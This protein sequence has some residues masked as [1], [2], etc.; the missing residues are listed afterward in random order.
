M[1]IRIGINGVGRVGRNLWRIIHTTAPD[2]TVAAA[3][4]T[5]DLSTVAHLL[6]Y[7][8][9]RGRFPATV[10]TADGALV[11][12][13]VPVPFSHEPTPERVDWG[14]HGVDLVIEAT[15]EFVRGDRA[16]GHLRG[17]APLVVVTTATPDADVCLMMGINE[18]AFDRERHRVISNSC[19]SVYCIAVAMSPLLATYGVVCGTVCLAY[20]HGS[21]PGPLLDDDPAGTGAAGPGTWR[22]L[23]IARANAI[24]LVPANV[25]GIRHALDR[26]LPALAGRI[27]AT[28]IRVP[29]RATSAAT[30]TLR[31]ARPAEA[32]QV[33]ATLRTAA[34]SVLK[35]YL[36]VQDQP[37][38]S[39]D[40]LGAAASCVVDASLTAS[41]GDLVRLVGWYDNEWG[42]AH[43]LV[44]LAR[45][46]TSH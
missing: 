1:A 5:A 8:T 34:A 30:L 28:A 38:V 10:E 35:P 32:E 22:N 42:Y 25:P 37:L 29:V 21:R 43:R 17:G 11:V 4:D 18:H 19:C 6:R 14:S 39:A 15:G 12:D 2:L 13:G 24:N 33:N 40:V 3:N 27:S 20:S 45:Y 23:R 9:V 41:L 44:D 7:D 31:L 46:L 16:R 26:V 36:E